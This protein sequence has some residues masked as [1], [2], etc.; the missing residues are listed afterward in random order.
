VGELTVVAVAAETRAHAATSAATEQAAPA[1]N[2]SVRLNT[3]VI[4]PGILRIP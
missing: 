1:I 3:R 2:P 4:Y